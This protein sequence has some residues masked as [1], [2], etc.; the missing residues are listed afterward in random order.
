[1]AVPLTRNA[2]AEKRTDLFA[3]F[4]KRSENVLFSFFLHKTTKRYSSRKIFAVLSIILKLQKKGTEFL[5]NDHYHH[6]IIIMSGSSSRSIIIIS[7]IFITIT[8]TSSPLSLSSSSSSSL[9]N[10][11]DHHYHHR[12][13]RHRYYN[14]LEQKHVENKVECMPDSVGH[15]CYFIL[16]STKALQFKKR[17]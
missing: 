8:S 15:H 16:Q 9:Q 3:V 7:T 4:S 5:G 2:F 12:R 14:R 13:R 1:M 11:F 6:L 10:H 17:G